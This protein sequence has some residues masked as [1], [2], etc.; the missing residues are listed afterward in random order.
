M[1]LASRGLWTRRPHSAESGLQC[2][3]RLAGAG[4]AFSVCIELPCTAGSDLPGASCNSL[5]GPQA[6]SLR[7]VVAF[8]VCITYGLLPNDRR[9]G[10]Y[11]KICLLLAATSAT[12]RGRLG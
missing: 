2:G 3:L 5:S 10:Q 7:V 9:P 12:W 8:A 4:P 6:G 1:A 11:G